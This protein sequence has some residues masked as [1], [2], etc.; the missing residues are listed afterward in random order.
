MRE[1]KW[2]V[3]RLGDKKALQG[4]KSPLGAGLYSGG[5]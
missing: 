4:H 5:L 3:Q 2:A 1:V